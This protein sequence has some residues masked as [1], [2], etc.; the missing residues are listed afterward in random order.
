MLKSFF[1][2]LDLL[3]VDFKLEMGINRSGQLVV[4]DEISPDSCR[5]WDRNSN[6]PMDKD[7]FLRDLGRVEEAYQQVAQRLGI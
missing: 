2:K 1:E 4:A 5:L 7:R 6:E 3:L